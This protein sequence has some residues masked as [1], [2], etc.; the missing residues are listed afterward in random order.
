[1]PKRNTKVI[2][3][4]ATALMI[5]TAIADN[6]HESHAN[7]F[8]KDVDAFHDALAPLWHAKPGTE[9]SQNVCA[10]ADKLENLAL[11]I[12]GSDTKPLLASIAALKAQCKTSPPSID[13]AFADVH[14]A[15]HHLT[16]PE[17]R[18]Q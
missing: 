5:C 10:Q 11:E 1:M 7:S 4:I 18:S 6:Q 15:F 8:V 3:A 17:R 13:A 2:A 16:E 9:R 12:H 14:E